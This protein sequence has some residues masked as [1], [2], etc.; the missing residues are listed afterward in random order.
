MR[1]CAGVH[2]TG[3]DIREIVETDADGR[4]ALSEAGKHIR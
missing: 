3:A 2:L 1:D 4:C